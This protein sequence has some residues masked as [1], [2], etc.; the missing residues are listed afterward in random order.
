MGDNRHLRSAFLT[1]LSLRHTLHA[2][3][4]LGNEFLRDLA[5]PQKLE[6]DSIAAVAGAGTIQELSLSLENHT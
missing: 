4:N 3:K 6:Q 1:S 5:A 2:V